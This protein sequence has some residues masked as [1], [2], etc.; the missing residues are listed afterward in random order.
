MYYMEIIENVLKTK[1]KALWAWQLKVG[2]AIYVGVVMFVI[3]PLPPPQGRVWLSF[4]SPKNTKK[5]HS[6]CTV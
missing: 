2:V 6:I 3:T 1:L 5:L 4:Q